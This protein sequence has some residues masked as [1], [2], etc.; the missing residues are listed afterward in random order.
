MRKLIALICAIALAASALM[1]WAGAEETIRLKAKT[2]VSIRVEPSAGARSLGTVKKGTVLTQVDI[3]GNWVKVTYRGDTGYVPKGTVTKVASI[4]TDTVKV[5][6]AKMYRYASTNSARLYTLKKG[7]SVQVLS[8]TASWVKV[9]Y[10]GKTGYIQ[11]KYFA[12]KPEATLEPQATVSPTPSPTPAPTKAPYTVEYVV[13]DSLAL[14]SSA[15]SKSTKL[16]K[17]S[18]GQEV[19]VYGTQGNFKKIVS[20]GQKGY[21]Y[22]KYLTAAAPRRLEGEGA[23]PVYTEL[24]Q[25]AAGAV[26]TALQERLIELGYMTGK[27]T[28]TFDSATVEA[29]KKYQTTAKLDVTGVATEETQSSLFSTGAPQAPVTEPTDEDKEKATTVI[30]SVVSVDWFK[31]NIQTVFPTGT[32]ATVTDVDTRISWQVK[33]TG[34]WWHADAQPLTSQDTARMFRACGGVWS[35]QRRAIWVTVGNTTYAA[36]MNCMPHNE[37]GSDSM[38][39]NDFDGCFCIHFLNSKVHGR[40]CVDADHQAAIAKAL[41]AAAT[42]K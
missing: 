27:S 1:I 5:G 37:G 22:G 6:G 12:A 29:V 15:S 21:V 36:S 34:G 42:L 4:T 32:I 28:G 26:V 13:L 18:Y 35:W 2:A 31:G 33:R 23:V 11:A 16:G 40:N 17:L 3:E 39:Y 20:G 41:A 9:K 7:A 25:G 30:K 38:P 24:R 19:H 14:Y 10:Y 8:S